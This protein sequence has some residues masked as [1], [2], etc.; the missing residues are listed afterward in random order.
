MESF[1]TTDA[2]SVDSPESNLTDIEKL[3]II[4]EL[5]GEDLRKAFLKWA[6]EN[7]SR[8]AF[9]FIKRDI[10]REDDDELKKRI[11]DRIS[12]FELRQGLKTGTE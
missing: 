11:A 10:N 2:T 3:K 6:E 7:Y 4:S 1:E 12:H 8:S 9:N 5:N